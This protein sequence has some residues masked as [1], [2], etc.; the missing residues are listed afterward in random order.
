LKSGAGDAHGRPAEFVGDGCSGK[1][2]FHR[3][4]SLPESLNQGICHRLIFLGLRILYEICK[5]RA[6]SA[7]DPL[8]GG[9][10]I[11]KM[12]GYKEKILF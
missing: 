3:D 6:A 5:F 10:L 4:M 11:L 9:G 12:L 8:P 1:G 7:T 2:V